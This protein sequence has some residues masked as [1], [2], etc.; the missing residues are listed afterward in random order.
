MREELGELFSMDHDN[1]CNVR[2]NKECDCFVRFWIEGIVKIQEARDKKL[3]S[4]PTEYEESVGQ[5]TERLRIKK[6]AETDYG[7][8]E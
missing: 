4:E 1:T 3:F 7:K 6:L 8:Q 5:R 2:Q